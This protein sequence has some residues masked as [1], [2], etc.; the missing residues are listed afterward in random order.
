MPIIT[1]ICDGA[2]GLRRDDVEELKA[3]TENGGQLVIST[4]QVLRIHEDARLAVDPLRV[5][6]PLVRVCRVGLQSR[7]EHAGRTSVVTDVVGVD[8]VWCVRV[9]VEV[10]CGKCR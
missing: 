7:E 3:A 6:T 1:S 4:L 9:V 8:A 2:A 10:T 5:T